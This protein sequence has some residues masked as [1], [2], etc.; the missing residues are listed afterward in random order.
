MRVFWPGSE[1]ALYRA[2]RVIQ[3]IQSCSK[4]IAKDVLQKKNMSSS[5]GREIA[6]MKMLDHPHVVVVR[7]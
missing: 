1:F 2:I 6:I 5:M 4:V 3:L 7:E